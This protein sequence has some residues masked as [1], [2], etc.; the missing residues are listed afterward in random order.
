MALP[1]PP[2][3]SGPPPVPAPPAPPTAS[4]RPTAG[5]PLPVVLPFVLLG[6]LLLAHLVHYLLPGWLFAERRT[7]LSPDVGIALTVVL[8]LLYAGL[9][10][11]VARTPGRRLV[12]ALVAASTIP[13]QIALH[14]ALRTADFDSVREIEI[15]TTWGATLIAVVQVAAWGIARREGR[16]WPVGLVAL[17][18]VAALQWAVRF[19]V[20]Q[21]VTDVV[22]GDGT[23]SVLVAWTIFWAWFV[24]PVL[25]TGLLCFVIDE[26]TRKS[27]STRRA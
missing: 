9:V 13:V 1:P 24:V 20:A 27:R 7:P 5:S 8:M 25:L 3:A 15:L 6:V 2:P 12:A 4:R 26:A 11:L 17:P 14:V 10:A 22:P 23:A 19:D 18:V 16:V 21:L